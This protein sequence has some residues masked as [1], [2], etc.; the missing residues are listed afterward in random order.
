MKDWL[1]ILTVVG[2]GVVIG[3]IAG[4]YMRAERRL[5]GKSLKDLTKENSFMS[6]PSVKDSEEEL[7]LY[8]I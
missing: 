6:K 8:F 7:E 2:A 4:K 3:T 1:K 5:M